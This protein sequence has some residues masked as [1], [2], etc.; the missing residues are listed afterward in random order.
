MQVA[1]KEVPGVSSVHIDMLTKKA[2][3]QIEKGKTTE[4]QLANAVNKAEGMHEY[5]AT[6]IKTTP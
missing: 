3:V 5:R 1:L 4:D 2:V 6:P